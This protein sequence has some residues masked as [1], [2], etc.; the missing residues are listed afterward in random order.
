MKTRNALLHFALALLLATR[1]HA[2]IRLPALIGDGMVLQRDSKIPVWG[3]ADPGEEVRI[4]FHGQNVNAKADRKG[5]WSVTLGACAAGGPYDMTI[6]GKNTIALHDILIG[7]VWLASGQSNMEMPLKVGPEWQGA[8]I[9]AEAE[10]ASA[11]F[12]QIR[13]FAVERATAFQ[14]KTDVTSKGWRAAN[15]E[16]VASFSAVAYFFGRELHQRYHVPIGLIQSVWGGTPAEAWTSKQGLAPFQEFTPA[17][18]LL[19]D[20]NRDRYETYARR[21]RIW[22]GQHASDDRAAEASANGWADP[23]FK[24]DNWPTIQIPR[25]KEEW[26]KDFKGFSGVV[27]FR[28]NLDLPK[29]AAGQDLALN[30]DWMA[31]DDVTYFNGTKVGESKGAEVH[32]NY[33]VPGHLVREGRNVIAVRLVGINSAADPYVGLYG[34]ADKMSV[35]F[36]DR[37][38][39]LAGTWTYQP[40][41]DLRDFPSIEPELAAAYQRATP[42]TTLFN[43]MIQPL[44]PYA[45]KGAIWY[46]GEAN[47]E[48]GRTTLYRTLFPAMIKDWRGRWGHDFPFLYVQLAGFGANKPEPAEYPWAELREAQTMAL[49]LPATAMATAVD[50][51]D[52]KDIHP[53]NKQDVAHR[54]ALAAAKVAYG[55]NI[56]HSGPTYQSMQVEGGKVR[57]LFSN[58][59]TGT[60]PEGPRLVVKDKYGYARGFE[61]AGA[62]GKFHWAQARQDG[63]SIVVYSEAIK[64]PIAVRYNWSNTPDGNLYNGAGLPAVPFRTDTPQKH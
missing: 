42:P 45:I 7:D 56:V 25:P 38:L 27:W 37:N 5:H 16:S 40:G 22:Y 44:N 35:A 31:R 2:D 17:L 63:D 50:L 19:N 14:P 11:K 4:S 61:I 48:E 60:R 1:A 15:P 13:L 64:E 34:A 3:W 52:E 55:E 26:G 24:A 9:S 33:A 28:R 29:E 59:G 54:L 10:I 32:R 43:A 47:A 8:V 18:Q 36:H 21:K 6:A 12:S 53:K 46:Q 58:L 57:I 30:L 49:S 51:G 41:P 62:D 23:N 39:P 20:K